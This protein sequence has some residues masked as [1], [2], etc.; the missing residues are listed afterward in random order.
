M[1]L[2]QNVF[3]SSCSKK[4]INLSNGDKIYFI[5]V[6]SLELYIIS[7][8]KN[9]GPN[10]ILVNFENNIYT[11]RILLGSNS[12]LYSPIARHFAQKIIGKLKNLNLR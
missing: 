6:P 4:C 2:P 3:I 8:T 5:S 7:D 9:F 12:D 10:W 1:N 11:T